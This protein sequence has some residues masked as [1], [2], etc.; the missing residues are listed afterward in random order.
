MK[1]MLFVMNPNAGT[2]RA[3]KY[4]ADILAIFNQA[5]YT[6]ITHMTACAGDCTRIVAQLATDM[7]TVVCCGGDG[8]F[9]ETVTGLMQCGCNIPI[10]YIPA[11]ST[12]DLAATL[13]LSN[14]P[15]EAARDIVEGRPLPYDVGSFGNRYFCY[16]ASFGI[17]TKTSYSTPQ[18]LK[19][20]LGR[21]AYLLSSIQEISQ[22]RTFHMR[23]DADDT[24]VEDDF[25]FGAVCNA[26]TVGG[27]LSL[28]PTQVDLSDG[29]FELMLIR[30]PRDLVE[31]SE[32][33][34]SLQSQRYHSPLITFRSVRSVRVMGEAGMVW[35][36]DGERAD[37]EQILHIRNIHNGMQVFQKE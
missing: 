18:N 28:D 14:N 10:G 9:N 20:A 2:R 24:S 5:G 37:A 32:V 19:N 6:V 3:A 36:T 31:L 34:Y 16:I 12:N 7:D 35:T 11:G 23:F 13:G 17:F 27:V 29:K 1:K 22:L 33:I 21:T 8:T 4:L 15:I 25:L 26:T 30:A